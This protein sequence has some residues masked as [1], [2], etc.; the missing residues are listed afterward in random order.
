MSKLCLIY[1]LAPKY[2][3]G[4]YK[5]IDQEYDCDWYMSIGNTDIK[6]FDLSV[7][8]HVQIL[9]NKVIF[10]LPW[11]YQIGVL[12]LV[13]KKVYSTYFMLGDVHCLSTWIF[14]FI[15]KCFYPHK[16][17]YFWSHGWYGK[18]SPL[19][20][21]LKKL[22]FRLADGTFL[23]GDYARALMIKD[24][25][26]P[27]RLF[28]IHNSL[29]YDK[30]I[31][32]R[33]KLKKTEIFQKHFGNK[34]KN[35]LFIGRLTKVKKLDLLINALK[36]LNCN[37]EEYNLT[38]IGDGVQRENLKELALKNGVENNVWFYG[39]C[40]DEK[41]NAELIYNADL[42]VSPGNVGLTAIHSMMYGTPVATHN[43]F[44]WQMPEFESIK[45]GVTGT[46]FSYENFTSMV[47]SIRMWFQTHKVDREEIRLA[48]YNEIDTY[49][50]PQYQIDVIREKLKL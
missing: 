22:F 1:N 2:R 43:C 15:I 32:L 8:K 41:I 14:A 37:G 5:L 6:E 50:N 40:Y 18:E 46:Y 42:C 28:V 27:D 34:C 26:Q 36:L 13:W 20:K 7:L 19:V 3:E 4:I 9:R 24:G 48:C 47:N 35:L 31:V 10:H 11:Y 29:D 38:L 44:K 39:A 33:K 45:E 30:Q 25:F 21:C 17:V 12:K 23:Y 49:W 16:K